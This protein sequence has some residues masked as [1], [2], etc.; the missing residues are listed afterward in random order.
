M[1]V[2]RLSRSAYRLG[3]PIEVDLEFG[4]VACV[5]VSPEQYHTFYFCSLATYNYQFRNHTAYPFF[6]FDILCHEI[7]K[8]CLTLFPRIRVRR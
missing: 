1:C 8:T 6:T 4:D 3:D 5:Q 7:S 2:V